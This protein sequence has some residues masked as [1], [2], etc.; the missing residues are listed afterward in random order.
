MTMILEM[1]TTGP[2]ATNSYIIGSQKDNEIALIDPGLDTMSILDVIKDKE[3]ELKAIVDTHGHFDHTFANFKKK[4]SAKLFIHRDDLPLLKKGPEQAGRWGFPSPEYIEP[5]VLLKGGDSVDI[6]EISLEV[7]HTPGHTPGGMSL[8]AN[9][10]AVVGDTL[11]AGSIGRTDFEGGDMDTLMSSIKG[12]LMTLP[13]DTVVYP[14]HGPDTTIG[15][16][17]ETNPFITG[18]FMSSIFG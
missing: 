11:F 4:T 10:I 1:F 7:V 15:H 17:R 14:G 13:D 5:D 2:L 16:E 8:T 12:K 9:G 6:G 18:S 3:W